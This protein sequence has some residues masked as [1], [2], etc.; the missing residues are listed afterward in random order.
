MT[1]TTKYPA[2]SHAR[3]SAENLKVFAKKRSVD[4]SVAN[5]SLIYAAAS[6]P[7]LWPHCDQNIPFRQNRYFNYLTGAHDLHEGHVTYDISKDKLT[8]YLP[9]LDKEEVMWSGMP[10]SLEQAQAKYDVDEVKYS[11]ELESDLKAFTGSTNRL[12]LA[13]DESEEYSVVQQSDLLLE[14]LDET[15][16][17]KDEYE[18]SL[19]K[20]ASEITDNSHLAVM[21]ALPIEKNEGHIH[22]EFVYHAMRQG[23]KNQAYDP[24]C[25][26]GVNC[27]TLHYTKNDLP[28][29]A[30]KQLVL[31]DAGAE[32]E[33]YAADVTRVFPINGEW[34]TE[35]R[36]IYEAVLDMQTQTMNRVAPGVSWDNLHQLSHEILIKHFLELGIFKNGTPEEILESRISASFYPHGLGHMLGMDTHDTAGLANYDDPDPMFKYLRIRRNLQANMVVTV[37]PGIYFN[38]FL[39]EPVL[40]NPEQAKYID[41]KVLEKYLPVGG[42]R[43]EDD[44]LVTDKGFYDLTKI[45]KDADEIAKIVK[46]GISKGRDHFHVVV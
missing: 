2:K 12:I 37:E 14:A 33:N 21:S 29:E 8:L 31:I 17:I 16:M 15:R 30:D 11:S 44:V 45:T 35:A 19:M 38:K 20:R 25:C 41:E 3:R 10:L 40:S 1:A 13:V 9:P 42:I 39:L 26:S 43:I 27:G 18:I 36:A 24:I 22:A 7:T 23:S 32:W 46:A 5:S 28:L 34:T 4:E 6:K